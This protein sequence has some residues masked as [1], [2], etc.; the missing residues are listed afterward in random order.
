M[1]FVGSM[2]KQRWFPPVVLLGSVFL[3]YAACLNHEFLTLWDDG[4][5]VLKNDAVRGISL[6]NLKLAFSS[7]YVGNYAPVHIL[8]YMIDYS[9]WGLVPA[10]FIATNLLL[11][12]LNGY[13]L[14]LLLS[15]A[16]GSRS[17][18][19]LAAL[20]FALHPVQVESV[21]W[22]S[23]RKTV[24]AL[25]FMLLALLRYDTYSRSGQGGGG[26]RTAYFSALVLFLLALLTKSVVVVLPLLLLGWDCFLLGKRDWR[27]LAVSVAPFMLLGIVFSAVT[28]FSQGLEMGGGRLPVTARPLWITMLTMLPVFFTYVRMVVLPLSLS[29]W[30][31]PVVRT[32]FDPEVLVSLLL[33]AAFVLAAVRMARRGLRQE[34]Y[35]LGVFFAGLLPVSNIIPLIT[36]MN[37]RYLYLP[38]VGVSGLACCALARYAVKRVVSTAF[39]VLVLCFAVLSSRQASNW[40]SNLTLWH[41]AYVKN[42]ESVPVTVHLAR[43]YQSVGMTDKA[44]DLFGQAL[45]R[46]PE[47]YEVIFR[48]GELLLERGDLQQAKQYLDR[49]YQLKPRFVEG[50]LALGREAFLR[51][52]H[53]EA[54][55]YFGEALAI[56]P[57][58]VRALIWMSNLYL[59]TGKRGEARVLLLQALEKPGSEDRAGIYYNLACLEIAEGRPEQAFTMLEQAASSGL[60]N[61]EMLR[62]NRDF[63]GIRGNSRFRKIEA[64]VERNG[65]VRKQA[66]FSNNKAE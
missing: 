28:V 66:F 65:S 5:Y 32:G 29:P 35:W 40:K 6:H 26:A 4:D 55:R 19:L 21:A 46:Q 7:F 41:A 11:H 20:L 37:D 25:F 47:N 34:V 30:Y 43:S 23:E 64:E 50:V 22:I 63:D 51:G 52:A 1:A 56:N 14:F 31:E 44:L 57:A 58:D 59:E 33:L 18:A 8:S 10:G 48:L 45:L 39:I 27:K 13:L 16:S 15:R 62:S 53:D 12:G 3:V 9:L 49:L 38:M 54:E 42:P 2:V 36:M 24:L 60:A 17:A 61:P